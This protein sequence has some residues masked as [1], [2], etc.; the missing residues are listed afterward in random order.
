MKKCVAYLYQVT[1]M[2]I[3]IKE[4]KCPLQLCKGH[5]IPSRPNQEY[6]LYEIWRQEKLKEQHLTD[7]FNQPNITTYVTIQILRRN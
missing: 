4:C 7:Q 2:N 1:E 3:P 5:F 6:C